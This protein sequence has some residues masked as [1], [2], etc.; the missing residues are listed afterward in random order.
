[1]AKGYMIFVEGQNP[2]RK[3]HNTM[4]SAWHEMIRLAEINEGK[5]IWIMILAKRM[6]KMPDDKKPTSVGSHF[7]PHVNHNM[8]EVYQLMRKKDLPKIDNKLTT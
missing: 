3:V 6:R 4:N 2:P 8:C 5:E 1:M 7:P